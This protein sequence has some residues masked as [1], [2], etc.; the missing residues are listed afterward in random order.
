[1]AAILHR[2]AANAKLA[3]CC[4]PGPF[5]RSKGEF[6]GRVRMVRLNGERPAHQSTAIA[7][8][9]GFRFE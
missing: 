5:A 1:M 4:G 2:T 8:G 7:G 9:I 6:G 3:K